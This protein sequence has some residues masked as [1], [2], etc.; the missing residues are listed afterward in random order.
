MLDRRSSKSVVIHVTKGHN[1]FMGHA[2]EIA[3]TAPTNTNHSNVQPLIRTQYA[4][5]RST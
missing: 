2:S 3:G 5:R 1:I 4:G